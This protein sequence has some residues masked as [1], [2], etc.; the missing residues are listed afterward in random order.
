LETAAELITNALESAKSQLREDALSMLAHDLRSPIL[1]VVQLLGLSTQGIYGPLTSEQQQ[2][3]SELGDN[4]DLLLGLINDMLDVCNYEAGTLVLGR[5][6]I[7][8][9]KII[10]QSVRLLQHAA[11]DKGVCLE[12]H[13]GPN[14]ASLVADEKRIMRVLI[15]LLDNAIRFSPPGE[16]V[17]LSC[18][19]L[20]TDEVRISVTDV[21]PGIP[22]EN[23]QKIF[24]KFYQA[25][26]MKAY[27]PIGVGL[28]LAF[29]RKTVQAHGG[30]IWVKSPV[31]D[32]GG[33]SRFCFTLPPAAISQEGIGWHKLREGQ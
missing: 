7:D 3:F 13:F 10:H 16:K 26:M 15:N 12:T 6:V 28:G 24:D 1:M 18:H 4:C 23:Q 9:P 19:R 21:G 11:A 31:N 8:V 25:W 27:S 33:G 5:T 32:H 17:V 29:C 14:V 22:K 20:V 30:K 2:V